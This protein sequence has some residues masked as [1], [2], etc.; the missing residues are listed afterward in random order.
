[1]LG[2]HD[3]KRVQR[4]VLR[5]VA[6][7]L[8]AD[9]WEREVFGARARLA[10]MGLAAYLGEE[11]S[12][13]EAA[14]V[15]RRSAH[16]LVYFD[17]LFNEPTL[18]CPLE[19]AGE[20]HLADAV[21]A[22]SGCVVVCAHFGR[23]RWIPVEMAMRGYEVV[24]LSDANSSAYATQFTAMDPWKEQFPEAPWAAKSSD[25][26]LVASDSPIGLWKLVQKLRAGATVLAFVDGNQGMHGFEPTSGATEVDFFGKPIWARKGI[27][28]MAAAARAPIVWAVASEEA[29][30]PPLLRFHPPVAQTTVE[31]TTARL[32]GILEAQIRAA[33]ERWEEW[34]V[35]ARWLVP[36]STPARR[37]VEPYLPLSV[38]AL[39]GRVLRL[40]GA[41][42][43]LRFRDGIELVEPS[44]GAELSLDALAADLLTAAS[45]GRDALAW[46]RDA[47]DADAA[48]HVLRSLSSRGLV[49]ITI[50]RAS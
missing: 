26:S 48:L 9:P 8:R 13:R 20:T 15:A 6:R 39:A 27:A 45:E 34:S 36:P 21:R 14:R 25:M 19:L 5:K 10:K 28:A 37:A 23:Y 42:A 41:A 32:F 31:E 49:E 29:D 43:A 3:A 12:R 7:R 11:L 38:P 33:P 30:G 4:E 2:A 44:T 47:H 16:S 17:E 1:M 18:W 35:A 46:I 50:G 40:G 24:L 22:G